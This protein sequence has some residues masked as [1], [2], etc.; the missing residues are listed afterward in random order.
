MTPEP[1]VIRLPQRRQRGGIGRRG[2]GALLL[3]VAVALVAPHLFSGTEL[4]RI[5]HALALG[6]DF[7]PERDDWQPPVVPKGYETERVAPAPYFVDLVAKLNLADLPDDWARTRAI[8]QHLLGSAPVLVGGPVQAGLVETHSAIVKQ[9]QGYCGDY[10]RAFMA[11]AGAAGMQVRPWA[12]SFDGFGGHGHI[13]V[14]VW[15]AAQSRW[16]LADVFDNYWFSRADDPQ[17]PLSALALRDAMRSGAALQLNLLHEGSRPGYIEPDKA[18]HYLRQGL[19]EWYL[20]W[21][22]NPFTFDAAPVVRLFAGTSRIL[23][24][25]G[26]IASGVQPG[27]RILAEP[28]NVAQREAMARLKLRLHAAML[29]G[30]L[31]LLLLVWP[32]R[33]GAAMAVSSA[34]LAADAWPR[35]CVVGP[36]PPPSGGMANQCEQLVRLLQGEGARVELVRTNAPYRP[37]WAGRVPMLR[38]AF[39][40][41]PY[42]LALWRACGRA[43][44]MHV[45]ANSGWAWHLCAAPALRIA[46]WRG[47]PT[48]VNYRGGQADDFFN[49]APSHVKRHLAA[50]ALRVTPSVFLQRVFAR[51]GLSAEII[52]NIIDLQRF[53]FAPPLA[54]TSA[55]PHVV[56]TRN[57]EAIYDIPTA[58]RAFALLRAT[59]PNARLTVAGSGPELSALQ[60]LAASLGI[61]NAVRFSGRIEN[62][63]IGALYASADLMLNPSTADNMPISILEALAS[64]VPVVSTRAGGIPDMVEH[65]RSALLVPV[66]DVQAMAEQ[67]LRLLADPALAE[68]LRRHG[69][70]EAARFAWPQVRQQWLSAYRR[71][72][73]ALA[74]DGESIRQH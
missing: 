69:R 45:F 58:L 38:A 71:A 61:A 23:E 48:I 55:G 63:D 17:L 56:V 32:R 33:S 59:H 74:A 73:V 34:P 65:G 21:G 2:L 41:L 66:G 47:V 67:A 18:W 46:A 22:R 31:G 19:A 53:A 39:R 5:R 50:A 44:V 11:I 37:A 3:V 64:G 72:G 25:V 10:V 14:E 70:A 8:T 9:G 51:H 29:L 20:P 49:A 36:L 26:A 1:A 62:A 52:P 7:V 13:W 40:L 16:Q 4:V 68:T 60:D 6:P 30:V 12:F 43:Q 28:G 27:I 15:N 54:A 42:L 57:L 35:V 24:G